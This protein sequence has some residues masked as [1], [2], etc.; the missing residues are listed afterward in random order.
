MTGWRLNGRPAA[1]LTTWSLA[2]ASGQGQGAEQGHYVDMTDFMV[3]NNIHTSVT[4]A[5]LQYYGEYPSG[6]GK[7]YAYPTEGDAVGWAYRKDL[8]EDPDEMAA[9]K[10]EY[11]YDLAPPETWDQLMD[12]AKFFTRPDDPVNGVKYG[13]GVYTQ[14]DYDGMIMGYENV[15]FS[16]GADWWGPEFEVEGYINS[17]KAVEPSSSTASCTPA[18][19]LQAPPMPS[20]LK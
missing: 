14:K 4:E 16:Y 13:V 9:F 18:V 17:D 10:A 6:S 20:L 1:T 2:T 5:T 8:F 3:S 11:G 19:P 7:Y 15:M 12:I